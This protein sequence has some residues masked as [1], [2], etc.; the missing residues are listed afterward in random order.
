MMRAASRVYVCHT[1]YHAYI[2]CVKELARQR[3]TYGLQRKDAGEQTSGQQEGAADGAPV[4]AGFPLEADLVLSTMSNDFGT[5]AERLSGKGPF[6]HVYTYDEQW[7]DDNEELKALHRDRGNIVAN[8]MQRIRYTKLLGKLQE[9][10]VPVDFAAYEDVYVFCDSDPIGYYLNW[11]KIRYHALEDGLNSGKLDNQARLSNWQAWPVKVL[12]AKLGLIFIECGYSRYCIDYEVND[13]AANYMPSR[14][15]FAEPRRALW[16]KL[17]PEDHRFLADAFLPDAQALR[18]KL[19]GGSRPRVMILT[20]PLCT[21]D[22]RARMF[23]DIVR[24]YAADCDVIIKPHPRDLVDYEALFREDAPGPDG[25]RPQTDEERGPAV[26]VL[27]GNFPMEVLDDL[28][29]LHVEKLISV[30]TQVDDVQFAKEILYLGLDFL[31]RYEDPAL[32]RKMEKVMEN[33]MEKWIVTAR[34][35]QPTDAEWW[36]AVRNDE[37]T[38]RGSINDKEIGPEEHATWFSAKLADPSERLYVFERVLYSQAASAEKPSVRVGQLRLS[39]K[40][41][42][43]ILSYAVAPEARGQGVGRGILTDAVRLAGAEFPGCVLVGEV[44]ADNAASRHLFET[45]GFTETGDAAAPEEEAGAC[46]PAMSSEKEAG[47]CGSAESSAGIIRFER[48]L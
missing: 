32:H 38:R 34:P 29:D 47:A 18:E 41:P 11:K 26:T 22:V 25:E 8:L 17:G 15:T 9:K 19:G 7:G 33:R 28:P 31:D 5:L 6:L 10:L 12:M 23:A 14:N 46:G 27:A 24:D 16:E 21:P 36:L 40:G 30:I 43:V 48:R 42:E 45:C 35:A 2:A 1:F 44:K 13:L 3:E 39:G 37:T 20:E 4:R